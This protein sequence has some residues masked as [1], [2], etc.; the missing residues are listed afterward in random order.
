[1]DNYQKK[2]KNVDAKYN[3]GKKGELGEIA[4]R[5]VLHKKSGEGIDMETKGEFIVVGFETVDRKQLNLQLYMKKG[6]T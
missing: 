4:S 3:A 5:Y 2:G 6:L 1:M